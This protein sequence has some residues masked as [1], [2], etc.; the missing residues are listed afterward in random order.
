MVVG[1]EVWSGGG[2]GERVAGGGSR[3]KTAVSG[4]LTSGG[5]H[6]RGE[7]CY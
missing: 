5:I 4:L 3:V 6:Q 1:A 2:S 7:Q